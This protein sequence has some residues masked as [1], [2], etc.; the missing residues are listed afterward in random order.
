MIGAGS[1][2]FVFA[3]PLPALAIHYRLEPHHRPNCQGLGVLPLFLQFRYASYAPEL[4]G[5]HCIKGELDGASDPQSFIANNLNPH[6]YTSMD[7]FSISYF[8]ASTPGTPEQEPIPNCPADSY[9]GYPGSGGSHGGRNGRKGAT[10]GSG[11]CII[12]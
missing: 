11:G 12:A 4:R 10:E 8:T 7:Y 1:R 6:T 5:L 2:I 3:K 9:N